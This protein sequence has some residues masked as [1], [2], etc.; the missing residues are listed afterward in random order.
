MSDPVYPDTDPEVAARRRLHL[1]RH[2]RR[3][4]LRE[5]RQRIAF[6]VGAVLVGLAGLAF[7]W[8]ADASFGLFQQRL[9]H[10]A[11]ASTLA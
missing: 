8:L 11:P 3:R 1:L 9:Q 4:R 6:W 2:R 10:S 5:W 7:A